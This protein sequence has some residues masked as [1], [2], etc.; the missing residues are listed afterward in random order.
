MKPSKLRILWHILFLFLMLAAHTLQ[1]TPGLFSINGAR[2]A[3]IVPF[4][5]VVA[6]LKGEGV[7]AVYG[8]V[9]GLLW[10]LS[11]RRLPGF[12]ALILMVCCVAAALLTIYFL[13]V[14][15]FNITLLTA[16]VLF[17]FCSLDYLFFYAIWGYNDIH[18]VLLQEIIPM[19]VY[20]VMVSPVVYFLLN[21]INGKFPVTD[22]WSG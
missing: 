21:K 18:I 22:N 15:W 2:P 19:A 14:I 10:D 1:N 11:S 12:S 8:A 9:G 16:A 6:V 13:R 3:L 7:G 5:L 20:T 4:V 17:I